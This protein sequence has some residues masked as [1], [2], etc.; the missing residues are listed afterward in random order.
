MAALLERL[1]LEAV[2]FPA[3]VIAIAASLSRLG[4]GAS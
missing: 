2:G 3:Y 4:I 1:G